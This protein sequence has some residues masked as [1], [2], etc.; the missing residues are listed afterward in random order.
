MVELMTAVVGPIT[1]SLMINS[2][3][4]YH[5]VTRCLQLSEVYRA[6]EK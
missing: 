2:K 3:M 1:M 4:S 6:V 5:I